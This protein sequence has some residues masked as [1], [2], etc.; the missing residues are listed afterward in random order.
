MGSAELFGPTSLMRARFTMV[1]QKD[2]LVRGEFSCTVGTSQLKCVL[3]RIAVLVVISVEP[4]DVMSHGYLSLPA[5]NIF[6]SLSRLQRFAVT[7]WLARTGHRSESHFV[8]RPSRQK[9]ERVGVRS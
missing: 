2:T 9:C 3:R 7:I 5:G 6:R 1:V 4:V 8:V